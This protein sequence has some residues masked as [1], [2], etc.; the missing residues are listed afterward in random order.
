MIFDIVSLS[1][2]TVILLLNTRLLTQHFNKE[3][4]YWNYYYQK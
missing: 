4:F 3:E 1:L 2:F